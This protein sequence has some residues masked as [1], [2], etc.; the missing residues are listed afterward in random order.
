MTAGIKST[1]RLIDTGLLSGAENMA[2]DEALLSSFDPEKSLPVLRLYGWS[3]AAFSYGRFQDPAETLALGKCRAAGVQV[4]RRITGGGLLYHGNEL[5]Y[6]LVCPASFVSSALGV[7]EAF[8]QLTAFL[9]AFYHKLGLAAVH[10]ADYY[11]GTKRLGGRTALCFAGTESCDI[12]I[13]G[14]KIGGNAQRRVK[15]VIFQHGSIPLR[16]M[17]AESQQ[18]LLSAAPQLVT[19]TT[20]LADEGVAV[21]RDTL[22][23]M[24]SA[25]FREVFNV[26][27][28]PA[29]LSRKEQEYTAEY[30][31]K[32]E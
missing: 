25:A 23:A 16:Q 13:N 30:M 8:F 18:Y 15:Q 28:H 22:A 3:P 17:A 11:G 5:T 31:Q 7:K 6:S 4:V 27:L 19:G 24:L 1:W 32:T 21:D 12:L 20:S 29:P 2:I 26:T 9:L 10:A 14:R